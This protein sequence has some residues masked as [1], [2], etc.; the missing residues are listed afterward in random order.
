MFPLIFLPGL[1]RFEERIRVLE[2]GFVLLLPQVLNLRHEGF[3]KSLCFILN[4]RS[5]LLLRVWRGCQNPG[6]E[7]GGDSRP[8]LLMT[9]SII[10][11]FTIQKPTQYQARISKWP[12]EADSR[13]VPAGVRRFNSCFSHLDAKFDASVSF[14]KPLFQTLFYDLPS[15]SSTSSQCF[16]S[17]EE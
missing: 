15:R 16:P 13:S 11:P 3:C 6:S 2:K 12:T 5:I 7:K 8:S 4:G 10:K 1:H 9:L 14:L 17:N